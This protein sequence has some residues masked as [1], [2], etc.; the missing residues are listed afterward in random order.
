M[1]YIVYKLT[2]EIL[3]CH[4]KDRY[5]IND[6]QRIIMSKKSE[7]V[8]FKNYEWKIESPH[9]TYKC[10]ICDNDYVDKDVKVRDHC[11]ITGNYRGSAHSGVCVWRCNKQ[12]TG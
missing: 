6:K 8:K 12:L 10:W 2:E 4:I 1:Y 9:I 3:K 11:H 7:Y 5:K